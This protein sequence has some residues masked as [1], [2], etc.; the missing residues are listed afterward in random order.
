MFYSV[1]FL[2][3]LVA[4]E[5]LSSSTYLKRATKVLEVTSFFKRMLCTLILK[6][7][8]LFYSYC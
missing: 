8:N 5:I 7:K 4:F 3:K 6:S 2:E 1:I